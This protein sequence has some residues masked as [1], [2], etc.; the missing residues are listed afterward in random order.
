MRESRFRVVA[1]VPAGLP[2]LK[3]GHYLISG[4]S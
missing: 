2:I 3:A 1:G 4:H